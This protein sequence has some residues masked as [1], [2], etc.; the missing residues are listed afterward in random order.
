MLAAWPI[1]TVHGIIH[2]HAGSNNTSG[3]INV[4]ID[5][6][7]RI[8]GFEKQK[9]GDQEIGNLIVDGGSQKDDPILQEPGVNIISPLPPAALLDNHGY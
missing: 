4:K 1:Q 5:I 2:R 3:G 8:F 6:L 9:L 7:V